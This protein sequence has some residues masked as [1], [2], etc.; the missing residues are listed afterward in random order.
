[1]NLRAAWGFGRTR[2][3]DWRAAIRT[4]DLSIAFEML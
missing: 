3:A 4:A 2:V 1:M